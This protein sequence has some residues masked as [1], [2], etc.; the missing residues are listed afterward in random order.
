[1]GGTSS[2]WVD[3]K[4]GKAPWSHRKVGWLVPYR[5]WCC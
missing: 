4:N 2:Y 3:G 1:M 5:S